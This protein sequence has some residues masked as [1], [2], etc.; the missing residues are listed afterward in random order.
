MK[1]YRKVNISIPEDFDNMFDGYLDLA[2]DSPEYKALLN[3]HKTKHGKT[4]KVY[5]KN[6]DSLK[7]R[8]AI[9]IAAR[10]LVA[11]QERLDEEKEA[12]K[13]GI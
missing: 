2:D 13:R 3:S 6:Q 5:S 9:Q 4:S 7:I 11:E 12:K 10:Y 1:N 8:F